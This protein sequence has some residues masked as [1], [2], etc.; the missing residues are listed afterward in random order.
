L[1][2]LDGRVLHQ[3]LNGG[4]GKCDYE[5]IPPLVIDMTAPRANEVLNRGSSRCM[6]RRDDVLRFHDVLLLAGWYGN[7]LTGDDDEQDRDSKKA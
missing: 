7:G 2:K 4:V 3:I 6:R 1:N 5:T